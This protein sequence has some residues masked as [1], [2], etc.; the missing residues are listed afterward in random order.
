MAARVK[1]TLTVTVL[2][3]G[4]AMGCALLLPLRGAQANVPTVNIIEN[5]AGV[6]FSSDFVV[7][8]DSNGAAGPNDYVEYINGAVA[9]YGK[10]GTPVSQISDT[11]FWTNAGI[12]PAIISAGLSDPR[13]IYDPASGH[14]FAV[15]ITTDTTGNKVLV[16]RSNSSDPTGGWKAVQFTGN[17]QFADFP[18]LGLDA[19]GVYVGTNNFTSNTGT[20]TGVSLFSIPKS[21][22][23]ASTP[24]L[25]N[26]TSKENLDSFGTPTTTGRG[27]TLQP[28]VD[29]SGAS[30]AILSTDAHPLSDQP[31]L[32]TFGTI[33][34][35]TLSGTGG[36]GA[37]LSP[38]T[39]ISG[40]SDGSPAPARQPDGT[41]VIDAG[42]NDFSAHVAQVGNLIFSARTISDNHDPALATHD[43]IDWTILNATTNTVVHEG[44]ISDP[45]FDY[46]YPSIAANSNG[47]ILLAFNRSGGPLSGAAGSVSA[48]A[49]ACQLSGGSTVQCG[50]PFLLKQGSGN[51]HLE[52]ELGLIPPGPERWGDYSATGRDPINTAN[53]WTVQEVAVPDTTGILTGSMWGTEITEIGFVGVVPE[54][55]TLALM[56]LGLLG[57]AARRR[58]GRTPLA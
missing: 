23:L 4:A 6:D 48:Y 15:Q 16:A 31:A 35:A 12:N 50:N 41:A 14:F 46:Y 17:A 22:L 40:L 43:Y 5:F 19:N 49:Q 28:A 7:P 2:A 24:T 20:F 9:I 44:M 39:K 54:P 53:F 27:G 26:M 51:Y 42:I 45:H 55:S 58:R 25:A 10:N 52:L 47:N 34:R 29:L 57:L 1:K 56:S 30:G 21:D 3:L 37:S 38:T 18:T 36:P 33:Y 32:S 11:T 8:P 13:T